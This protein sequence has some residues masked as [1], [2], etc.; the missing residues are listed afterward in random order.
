MH[1]VR[2]DARRFME[3]LACHA[4][5][6][7]P[8]TVQSDLIVHKP[9]G[10]RFKLLAQRPSALHRQLRLA[11]SDGDG[12]TNS[13]MANSAD[14]IYWD[15]FE[16]CGNGTIDSGEACDRDNLGAQTC[17]TAGYTGGSLTCTRQCQLDTTQCTGKVC[18]V[19][20]CN[21]DADCGAAQCGPVFL[22]YLSWSARRL[23]KRRIVLAV[24]LAP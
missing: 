19:G 9:A 4:A 16:L 3:P 5:V 17:M 20:T 23:T 2:L 18:V 24:A 13:S 21:S 8:S 6:G 11:T 14:V 1:S 15:A 10:T 7:S 22:E 12:F